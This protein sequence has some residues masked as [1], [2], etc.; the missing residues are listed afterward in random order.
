MPVRF[1]FYTLKTYT[2]QL[3]LL[4][5]SGVTYKTLVPI[6]PPEVTQQLDITAVPTA[7]SCSP[8]WPIQ[9][10]AH[11]KALKKWNAI[12]IPIQIFYK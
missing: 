8:D 9:Y 4:C 5:Y 10:C 6:H 12:I 11:Q 1:L 3:T 7:R 2:V